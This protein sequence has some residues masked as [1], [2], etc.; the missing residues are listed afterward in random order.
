MFEDIHDSYKGPFTAFRSDAFTLFNSIC[1]LSHGHI[2]L[3]WQPDLNNDV[4]HLVFEAH[5]ETSAGSHL[6]ATYF[7]PET[8][9]QGFVTQDLWEGLK[10]RVK[11][12]VESKCMDLASV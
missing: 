2:K 6:N 9:E 1:D 10:E 3:R 8:N 5:Q 7:N 4:E 12:D 11:Q